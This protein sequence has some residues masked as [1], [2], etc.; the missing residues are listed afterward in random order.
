[1]KKKALSLTLISIV[2]FVLFGFIQKKHNSKYE[3]FQK[4]NCDSTVVYFKQQVMPILQENCVSCHNILNK[5]DDVSLDTFENI[6][7]IIGTDKTND[8]SK[9]VLAKVI[10]R[11]RM[12]PNPHPKLTPNQKKIILKWIEQGMQNNSCDIA[13]SAHAATEITFENHINPL[14]QNNCVSCHNQSNTAAGIDLTDYFTI[15][16]QTQ[17][18]KIFKTISHAE[19]VVAMPLN[20]EKLL[21]SEIEMFATWEKTGKN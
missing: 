3:C 17:N 9:N 18:G 14:L 20:A 5:K 15:M 6:K 10:Q 16:T 4:T 21:D 2:T 19:G 12:P 1:M 8:F 13:I 11:D 7:A